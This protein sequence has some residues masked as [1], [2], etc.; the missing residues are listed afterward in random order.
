[1]NHFGVDAKTRY[2]SKYINKSP[3]MP[4]RGRR[5][6]SFRPATDA[7]FCIK[8][9][10]VAHAARSFIIAT[11]ISPPPMLKSHFHEFRRYEHEPVSTNVIFA[12]I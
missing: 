3:T 8:F 5:H 12:V 10:Y 11:N 4:G 2:I 6:A 1:M 9:K 7:I